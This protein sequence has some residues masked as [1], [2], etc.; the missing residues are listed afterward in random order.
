MAATSAA[1]NASTSRSS[2]TARWVADSA[3]IPT[4]SASRRS[5]RSLANGCTHVPG[6]STSGGPPTS[7]AAALIPD[8]SVLLM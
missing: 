1:V 6:G 5:L 7:S 8:G 2:N 3:C 4:I